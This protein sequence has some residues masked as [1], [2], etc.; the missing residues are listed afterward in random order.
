MSLRRQC[1]EPRR[2]DASKSL[3]GSRL[4]DREDLR[5]VD[6]SSI[7]SKRL[8][9]RRR[10]TDHPYFYFKKKRVSVKREGFGFDFA[11]FDELEAFSTTD[12]RSNERTNED[13]VVVPGGNVVIIGEGDGVGSAEAYPTSD[14][15]GD[16]R[17]GSE[18]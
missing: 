8:R 10:S 7:K 16:F 2:L 3:R 11:F 9:A 12:D 6:T 13:D 5:V 4:R 1:S 18:V 17:G 14:C 15:D